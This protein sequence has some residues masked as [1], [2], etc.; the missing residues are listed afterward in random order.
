MGY[1]ER[2]V[3]ACRR[4]LASGRVDENHIR[5]VL[6]SRITDAS[7]AW[8]YT[9]AYHPV[10]LR[11]AAAR[12][13][14]EKDQ[15]GVKRVM[16]MVLAEQ[17]RETLIEL[18]RILGKKGGGLEALEN[19]VSSEDTMVRDAAVDMFRRAGKVDALFLLIFNED[20]MVVKRIKRYID[21][22]G[23]H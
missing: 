2:A 11:I 22:A 10:E 20:D 5:D 15:G 8:E 9:N 1:Q 6:R 3:E 23:Q 19:L 12:V 13:I 21:E 14:I 18:L 17:E 7:W 4:D 16:D